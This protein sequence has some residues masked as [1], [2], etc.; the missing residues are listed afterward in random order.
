[1]MRKVLYNKKMNSI[2]DFWKW[3][4]ENNSQFFFLNQISDENEKQ[5]ILGEFQ[6]RLS[7]YNDNLY[8]E[9]GGEPD[10]TQELIISAGGDINYFHE[11]EELVNNAPKIK[12]WKII[13]FK[14][15]MGTKF[16]L[17]YEGIEISPNDIWF[18]AFR[19]DNKN[20]HLILYYNNYVKEKE[21]SFVSASY[22]ALDV[23]LGEKS[24]T[25]NIESIEVDNIKNKENNSI[26]L[27][28][29]KEFIDNK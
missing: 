8:F 12:D 4:K 17:N 27:D 21:D 1:M 3:F 20:L 10:D 9:I 29:I 18:D 5:R 11:V 25:M 28:G 6:A 2:T 23:I 15:S 7:K 19:T 22:I 14:P 24:S 16:K 26:R 13:A